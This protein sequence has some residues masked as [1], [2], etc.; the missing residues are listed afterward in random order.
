MN[1]LFVS[2][3]IAPPPLKN[4]QSCCQLVV[5]K[6]N[7]ELSLIQLIDYITIC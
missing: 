6:V 7:L 3:K 1:L 5:I 4:Q 2:I